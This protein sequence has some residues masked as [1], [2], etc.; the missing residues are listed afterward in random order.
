M[1]VGVGG[2]G[3]FEGVGS[4]LARVCACSLGRTCAQLF[5]S[6][7]QQSNKQQIG[8]T[9]KQFKPVVAHHHSPIIRL[10]CAQGSLSVWMQ[11]P[12]EDVSKPVVRAINSWYGQQL[13][14]LPQA[15]GAAGAAAAGAAAAGAAAGGGEVEVD[16][17]AGEPGA[18]DPGREVI[19]AGGCESR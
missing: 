8:H 11:A 13:D 4:A 12:T 14:A 2:W 19:W 6:N 7:I 5:P 1:L 18:V 15:A 3:G 16:V 17:G 9:N 10:C